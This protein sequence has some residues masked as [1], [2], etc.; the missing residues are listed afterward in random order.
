MSGIARSCLPVLWFLAGLLHERIDLVGE[1]FGGRRPPVSR[2]DVFL[3]LGAFDHVRVVQVE[4]GAFGANP[5]QFGE[6]VPGGG[7]DVA[8]SRE[9]PWPQGSSASAGS[10]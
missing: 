8:H 7:H 10:P 9:L 1:G 4:G 6:V 3:G 5:W 2:A